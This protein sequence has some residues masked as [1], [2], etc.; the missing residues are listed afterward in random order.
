MISSTQEYRAAIVGDVRRMLIRAIVDIVDPDLEFAENAVSNSTSKYSDMTQL[1]DKIIDNPLKRVTLEE[2]R[3]AL[4]G[5]WD[6][7]P[8]DEREL[9]GENLKYMSDSVCDQDGYFSEPVYVEQQFSNVAILQACTVYFNSDGTDAIPEDFTVQV[10]QGGNAYYTKSFTGNELSRASLEGF[11]VYNP[12]SIRVTVTKMSRPFYRFRAVEI[13]PGIHEQWSGDEFETFM[14]YHRADFSCLSIPYGTCTFKMDNVD[15]RFEPRNKS[16]IFKSIQERQGIEVYLGPVLPD[17]TVEYKKLG[18]FYQWDGGW[19]TG[20]NGLTMQWDLVDIVG[21]LAARQYIVPDVLPT[22]LKEWIASIVAQLGRKFES[23][24]KVDPEYA[25]LPVT[26]NN[27]EDING[28][29]CGDI[30]RYV[31]MVTLTFPRA[32]QDSGVLAVDPLWNEG[33]KITLDNMESYPVIKANDDVAAIIFNIG[34]SD[35]KIEYVVSGNAASS[36]NTV[37]VDN[38]FIHTTEDAL[39]SARMILETYGGSLYEIIG[40]GD[41]ASEIGDVDALWLDE[42][43]ATTARRMEQS[44][45]FNNGVLMSCAATLMQADGSFMFTERVIITESGRWTAPADKTR[46]RVILVGK[47]SDGTAGEPGTWDSNG[48]DGEDGS[49]GKVWSGT[50]DINLNQEFEITIGEDTV[51]GAYSSA[52]GS[53]YANGYTDI[54]SGDCY[55]RTGV[56]NPVAGSGDGGEKGYGGVKGNR[57]QEEINTSLG[58]SIVVPPSNNGTSSSPESPPSGEVGGTEIVTVVDNYPGS[59]S[60]GKVGATGCVVVYWEK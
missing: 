49:G 54:A 18:I 57:H 24:H 43:S 55:A 5:T 22:T 38:P 12:D 3:W 2:D 27:K 59:G 19:K 40:R 26:V 44:F 13:V 35:S 53:V 25:D 50:I 60:S 32:D 34:S 42:S 45:S 56:K 58:T 48:A 16:G 28:M 39:K 36:G 21:L 17:G 7:Y 30:L 9:H 20:D 8:E 23:M 4:D 29:T 10:M 15:R 6:L 47:G 41:P 37:T 11:T 33:N 1:H 31:C 46:L 52:N 14:V 51:F